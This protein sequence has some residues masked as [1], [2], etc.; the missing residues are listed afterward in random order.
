MRRIGISLAGLA[1][2]LGA[3]GSDNKEVST[4][5]STT[6]VSSAT[7]TTTSPAATSTSTSAATTTSAACPNTGSTEPR[8]TP[9][10]QPAAL[11]TEVA[12]TNVDCR[13]SVTFTFRKGAVAPPSCQVEYR[14]GPFSQDGSG[15]PLTVS[16]A[17]FV[18]VRCFPA[19][20]YDY[21]SGETTYTGP[22]R[23][24]PTGTRHVRELVEMGDYE[25][26]LNWVIGLDAQRSFG[27][28]AGGTPTRQLV[29]TF[30]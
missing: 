29:I 14:P 4:T 6:P 1:C 13:D 23:I 21:E 19:Y 17:A 20:G 24:S 18:V 25:A 30:S 3:C 10:S 28:T 2:L 12:V 5:T 7:T 8:N 9:A 16:G 15:A 26:T 11:L 27:I 22:K